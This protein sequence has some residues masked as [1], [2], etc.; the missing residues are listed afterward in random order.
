MNV[1]ILIM[2]RK[3]KQYSDQ[4]IF[5]VYKNEND[6]RNVMKDMYEKEKQF[7][8]KHEELT[9]IIIW[10]SRCEFTSGDVTYQYYINIKQL[11]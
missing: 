9:N 8:E 1:H 3:T 10:P 6:A 5:G 11:N 4:N 2:V 7:F